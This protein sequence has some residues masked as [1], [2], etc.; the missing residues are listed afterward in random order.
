MDNVKSSSYSSVAVGPVKKPMLTPKAIIHQKFGDK[1]SYN[2]EEVQQSPKNGCPGLAI[3]RKGP[4]LFICRLQLPE[5]SVVSPP[6]KRKKE[7]EQSAAELALHKVFTSGFFILSFDHDH[8]RHHCCFCLF[9][10][11]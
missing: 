10:G 11:Q 3:S 9:Y 1:A 2:L 8:V 7:A 6:C 4:C 5:F